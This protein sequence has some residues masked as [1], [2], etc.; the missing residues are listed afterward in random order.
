MTEA[1]FVDLHMHSTASDGAQP[2]EAVVAAAHESIAAARG[3]AGPATTAGLP[4]NAG[5]TGDQQV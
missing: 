5:L 2:P 3:G 4:N 1:A